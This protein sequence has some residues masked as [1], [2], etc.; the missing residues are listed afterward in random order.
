MLKTSTAVSSRPPPVELYFEIDRAQR[1]LTGLLR[2]EQTKAAGL[3]SQLGAVLDRYPRARDLARYCALSMNSGRVDDYQPD[4]EAART[5]LRETAAVSLPDAK[6]LQT[7]FLGKLA[8]EELSCRYQGGAPF[9]TK[10][11]IFYLIAEMTWQELGAADLS[12]L[13]ESRLPA[14]PKE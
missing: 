11:Q 8:L 3:D 9:C 14:I 2:L 4:V 5:F 10:R 7:W 13:E 1:E 6:L 12:V